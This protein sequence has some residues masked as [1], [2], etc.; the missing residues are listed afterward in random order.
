MPVPLR[1]VGKNFALQIMQGGKESQCAV[2]IV[3]VRA[4]GHVPLAQ[5]KTWLAPFQ[6]LALAFLIATQH[7]RLLR[8]RQI[9]TDNV[10]EF[11][12]ELPVVGQFERARL[13]GFQIVAE[14]QLLNPTL[15]NTRLL[16]H[17]PATPPRTAL[18]WLGHLREHGVKSVG[19][20]SRGPRPERASSCKPARPC[21][22]KRRRHL[23]TVCSVVC[24]SFAISSFVQFKAARNM[25]QARSTS[26]WLAL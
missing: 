7:D 14:P 6:R 17:A 24:N 13:V 23:H 10:P 12:L 5:G 1:A 25:I 21:R 26:V 9:Q 20:N 2:A 3:I 16:G 11:L 4:C 15:G 8:W 18:R 19:R 22:A